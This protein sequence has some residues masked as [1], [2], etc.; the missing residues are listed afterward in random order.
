MVFTQADKA[1]MLYAAFLSTFLVQAF[2]ADLDPSAQSIS[3]TSNVSGSSGVEGT[4]SGGNFG[5]LSLNV[6]I[7]ALF[8]NVFLFPVK[9]VDVSGS[10]ARAVS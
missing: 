5:T 7:G 1:F 9:Y 10:M 4:S 2:I 8:A 3:V 6:L